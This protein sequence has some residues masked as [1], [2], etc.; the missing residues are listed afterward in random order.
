MEAL[1]LMEKTKTR[2]L[3][4]PYLVD[5]IRDSRMKNNVIFDGDMKRISPLPF[6]W[7]IQALLVTIYKHIYLQQRRVF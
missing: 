6:T 2:T 7:K 4:R 1:E 3:S 5:A